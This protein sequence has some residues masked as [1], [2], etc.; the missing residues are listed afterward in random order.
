MDVLKRFAAVIFF[1]GVTAVSKGQDPG[2]MAAQQATMAAQQMSEQATQQSIQQL[3]QN[4][5]FAMDTTFCLV[6]TPKISV[7]SGTYATPQS[8]EIKER[9]G[10]T[11]IF[12]TLHGWT[13][14]TKS[15]LYSGPIAVEGDTQLRVAAYRKG[16]ARSRIASADYMVKGSAMVSP[17][18]GSDGLLHQGDRV[19]LI[20]AQDADSRSARVGQT[21]TLT[22]AAPMTIGGRRVMPTDV[23]AQAVIT[24]VEPA[25]RWGR[26]P[27]LT[28]NVSSLRVD[29]VTVPLDAEVTQRGDVPRQLFITPKPVI[30]TAGRLIVARVAKDTTFPVSR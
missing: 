4:A 12:Y 10:K 19:P 14:T 26:V 11:Q 23:D 29:G 25:K 2:M 6:P 9:L 8:V 3:N 18:V 28:L 24:G 5:M 21:M 30:V 22:L 16:C 7:K 17:A 13:P 1:A 27:S 20:F 15:H